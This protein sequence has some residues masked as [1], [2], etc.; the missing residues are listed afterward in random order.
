MT[1][2]R[3]RTRTLAA[4]AVVIALAT[5][6]A[7]CGG[8]KSAAGHPQAQGGAASSPAAPAPA[9][10]PISVTP[11][12]FLQQVAQKT[13][14]QKSAKVT[15]DIRAATGEFSAQ[16]PISWGGGLTGDLTMQLPSAVTG[17][18]G[19]DGAAEVIYQS[20][21]MYVNLHVPQATLDQMGGKHWFKYSY[22]DLAKLMGPA[23]GSLSNSLKNADP[24]TA[25]QT[26]IASGQVTEVGKD[27]V[28][29]T[30]ATHYAA[31]LDL[32]QMSGA[33]SALTQDQVSALRQQLKSQGV[34]KA[35][36]DVW[37]D[38]QGLLLKQEAK[39]DTANGSIDITSSYA[40]YGVQVTATPPPAADTL[41]AAQ[42]M[43]QGQAGS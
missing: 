19:T 36:Y 43:G 17:K 32:D 12:G 27:P 20:D 23:G 9:R 21:A 31:D 5:G 10:S 2:T 25:V 33:G 3:T 13:G 16:G 22:A 39:S 38:D 8:D 34:T 7:A 30:P 15:E 42:L 14:G 28:N 35:H 4:T 1:G 24:V 11:A 26:M 41:D 40:D 6:T 18:L 29:G 37:V